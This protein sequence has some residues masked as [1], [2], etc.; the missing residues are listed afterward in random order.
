ML[1][2][3]QRETHPAATMVRPGTGCW[4]GSS[5]LL[6]LCMRLSAKARSRIML[7]ISTRSAQAKTQDI[8]GALPAHVRD[9]AA[10]AEGLAASPGSVIPCTESAV[11]APAVLVH[12]GR[13]HMRQYPHASVQRHILSRGITRS[14]AR[15]TCPSCSNCRNSKWCVSVPLRHFLYSIPRRRL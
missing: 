14:P 5:G 7:V 15:D 4:T 2:Q 6:V 3:D 13:R 10:V 1:A 9:Y 12:S 11:A 8:P